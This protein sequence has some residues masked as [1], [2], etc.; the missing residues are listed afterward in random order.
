MLI[1]G[2]DAPISENKKGLKKCVTLSRSPR[3]VHNRVCLIL[4]SWIITARQTSY[5]FLKTK[6]GKKGRCTYVQ[7]EAHG[8]RMNSIKENRHTQGEKNLVKG[9]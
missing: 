3:R 8:M 2:H 6:K 4:L 5:V 7:I 9:K 1:G